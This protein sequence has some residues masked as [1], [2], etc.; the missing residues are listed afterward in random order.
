MLGWHIP[1]GRAKT[2]FFRKNIGR[3]EESIAYGIHGVF[4]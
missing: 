4:I 2:R 1:G 3:K